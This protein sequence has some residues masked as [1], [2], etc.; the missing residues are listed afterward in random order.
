MLVVL[1]WRA[2]TQ[3]IREL[4]IL[5]ELEEMFDKT[6]TDSKNKLIVIYNIS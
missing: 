3:F 1:K 5:K 6:G 4:E 2:T